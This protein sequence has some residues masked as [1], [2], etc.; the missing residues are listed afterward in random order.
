MPD[1][2]T[3]SCIEFENPRKKTY[4]LYQDDTFL[5][6]I[7]EDTLVH[8]TIIKGSIFSEE[9]FTKII[10]Y[11][12]VN[13]CVQQ[14]YSYLQRRPHLQQELFRKLLAKQ[15]NALSINQAIDRLKQ[16]N[17]INDVE[18]ITFYIKDKIK[19]RKT[20]PML[21]KKKLAEKGAQIAEIETGLENLFSEDLQIEIATE[22]LAK[23]NHKLREANPLKRKQKLVQFGTGRGFKWAILEIASSNLQTTKTKK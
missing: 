8:F 20:G 3:I 1:T 16:K 5:I 19:Q 22:M 18:V 2:I 9:E 21:I 4:S 23:K 15:F 12:Q 17:Y 13:Q 14:A 10:S 11:D 6:E 7:S